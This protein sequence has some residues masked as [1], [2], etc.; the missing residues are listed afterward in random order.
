MITALWT[1]ITIVITLLAIISVLLAP[2]SRVEV[3]SQK[4]AVV[5]YDYVGLSKYDLVHDSDLILMGNVLEQNSAGKIGQIQA[6]VPGN[7]TKIP[8]IRNTIEVEKLIKGNHEGATIDVITEG[9]LSG[10]IVIEGPAK[11]EKDEKTIL[12][13]SREKGYGGE[14][15]TMGGSQGKYQVGSN[16]LV[17]GKLM[18][19]AGNEL[20]YWPLNQTSVSEFSTDIEKILSE[21]KP[22]PVSENLA[23]YDRDLT[24]EEVKELERNNTGDYIA[25]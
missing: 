24:S 12:F 13:L 9:D 8:G 7:L 16:D 18:P 10:N 14:Y 25:K 11:F 1:G 23:P 17:Q 6:G 22:E 5:S 2:G 19:V 20:A 4:L 3:F 21:P 15:T